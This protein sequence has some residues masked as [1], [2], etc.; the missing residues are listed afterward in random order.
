MAITVLLV[1]DHRITR[2]GLRALLDENSEI[3][4]VGEAESGRQ[5]VEMAE[6]LKPSLVVMDIGMPDLNGIEATRQIVSM[7]PLARVIALSMH[8]DRQY[9]AKM[10]EA[11]AK[12]YLLKDCAIDE[13]EKAITAVVSGDTYLSP[14]IAGVVIKDYVVRL[15]ASQAVAESALTDR[16]R[17]VLQ[18]LAEG[19]STKEI[20]F[21]LNL[22]G[23][24]IETHRRNIM[25]KLGFHS[26][27][28]ITKYAIR[29][30]LT[31]LDT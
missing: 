2:Q 23:K 19:K 15:S 3:E 29:Q 26:L 24:T 30:G 11:G 18:L 22:S 12:G 31:T 7:L 6:K 16:E 25:D 27:A 21:D 8:S 13:L 5:A 9:V 4:V 20:A 17:E 1:D 14:K 10:L 28:E